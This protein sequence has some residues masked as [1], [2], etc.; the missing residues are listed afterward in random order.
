MEGRMK[1]IGSTVL[2]FMSF[3][4][5]PLPSTGA[6]TLPPPPTKPVYEGEAPEV[7]P[8]QRLPPPPPP[9]VS[10]NRGT[11]EGETGI[12]E[13][14]LPQEPK[15]KVVERELVLPQSD[16]PQKDINEPEVET[17]RR[18]Y[19]GRSGK[20][21]EPST[22]LAPPEGLHTRYNC[23]VIN[24][25]AADDKPVCALDKRIARCLV[26]PCPDLEPMW[27]NY[28]NAKTACKAGDNII[29][30]VMGEC[31]RVPIE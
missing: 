11:I 18:K 19:P 4:S 16:D 13:V 1:I 7:A 22:K 28:P 31:I 26:A 14:A 23:R 10:P 17:R 15:A 6:D 25:E 27:F 21:L 29:E 9:G 20:V 5:H 2:L 3:L 12:K 8:E 24:F 30:Y